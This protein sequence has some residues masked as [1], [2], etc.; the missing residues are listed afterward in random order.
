MT[1]FVHLHVHSEYSLL[2][3]ACRID[4]LCRRAAETGA[5]AVALT[6]H[7]VMYGA[8]EFYY[9]AREFGLTPIIGCEAYL[10]PRGRLDRTAREEAHVTLLAADL[11]GY[12]NL[13]AL[14][15]KGFL[16]GYYYKPRIDLEL[17]AKHNEGLIAL[18]GCI[19]GLVAAPL[20]RGDRASALRN[21]KTYLEI[22]GDRFYIEVM[23]H[24]MPE[25]DATNDG[26]VEVARELGVPIVATN[27]SHYLEQ[28]DAA[29]HDVLLCIGT[30]KTVSDTNRMR[31]YS[32]QFYVKSSEEMRSLWSDLPEA[33]ENTAKIAARV[34]IRIPEKIFHLPQ[35]PVPQ[36]AGTPERS[37]DEYL[38]ELCELGLRE[39]Y[40]DERASGDSALRA[41]LEYELGVITK[42][43]FSSYFLIVWDFIKYARDHGIPVGPGRGS[44]VGSLV[45][46]CLRITDLDPLTFNLVFERFLNPD[47]ISMPDIDTDFCVD[48]RDEVIA[49]VTEKYGKD[50]VAQIVTFGT[51]AARAA[52][53]DAGR[54]LGVP[55]ADVDRVAKLVPSGPGGLSI[56][57]AIDQIAELKSLYASRLEIR[58]LLDTAKEIEGLA[59]NAGTHAAGVVISAGPLIDYTPLVRFGDGGINTQYDMDW[60]ERIGLLKMDFLGLR[61]LTV[62]QN[63]VEEI[64]R[65]VDPSFE[66]ATIPIDDRKT[67]AMLGRGETMGVFQLESDGMRRVCAE[68]QPSRF[69]D[70]VALVALYR[71]GPMD[72]IPQYVANKH[73]RGKPAYLHPKLEP[74]LAET[75]GTAVYQEQAMQMAREIAGF[76]MGEA[77]ELRKVMGKKQ[78]EKIPIYQEK[79]VHGAMET[80]GIDRALAERIFHFIEPFAGYGFNKSHAVAY[81]WIAYQTAYLKANHPLQYLTALMTSV[82]DKTEK[83]V[84]Y[85]DEAKK[86]GIEVLPPDVNE[87]LTDFAVVGGA[88]RFGL[89]AIKGVGG[90]AVGSIIEARD[91]DGRF[92]DLFDLAE[93]VD[94]KQVNRRV[95]EALIKCGALDALPGNRAQKLAA[96]DGALE[97]A[98]RTTR[99]AEV[100][101]TSLFGGSSAETRNLA[102]TLPAM[103]APTT[104]E[105]LAWERETLGIFVSGHPLAEITPLL[106]R[107]GAMPIK[108]LRNLGDDAAVTVG[109]TI[110][111]VRR[112]L[113]KAGQQILIAQLED[114][115]GACDVVLFAKLY[116]QFQHLFEY[117]AIVI[118]KG[119][120]RLRERPGAAPGDE[121]RVELSVAANEAAAFDLPQARPVS[122]TS[123]GWHVDVTDREQIDRLARLID[124]WPGEVPVMMHVRGRSQRVARAIAADAR[125]RG[126]LERIFAPQG[127]REGAMDAYG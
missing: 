20:L 14:V 111:G 6:D 58:K 91:R 88:I 32:D 38:R 73:G 84:E 35:F 87:S 30:G 123:R 77:D 83:L 127:V 61:N 114:T 75:Y 78:K 94:A 56:E 27:D 101:Q 99:D 70:V 66:L 106:A 42:M 65:T 82:G 33:Y 107:A 76:T 72:W 98:A 7:G 115:G 126:E 57:R 24:G 103:A 104:R 22:F 12:R 41:R 117:D 112:M 1:Q 74:I 118:V 17:L 15:S 69:E 80:S 4:R 105:M 11:V 100:G 2:D 109:G 9:K 52:I 54:A 53:R 49:Y 19:S 102:P 81:A 48:R 25:Q 79:F 122:A 90:G 93:R 16:E 59:R 10:A 13:T 62:M 121:P 37:D 55:L 3:G 110:T 64:R 116:A 89:A 47:R 60:I 119:R 92:L 51:M 44:A 29:A 21:A 120:V 31:F 63:A 124:E 23:R 125:V 46:Y 18:S 108:E 67:Y 36:S 68:L 8:M 85:I 39:R 86:V 45:A 97:L 71:P 28:K 26:L 5:T 95:F 43:G 50:R 40:G 34:D 96:L 113:T